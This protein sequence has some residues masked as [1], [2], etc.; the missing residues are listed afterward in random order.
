MEEGSLPPADGQDILGY[1]DDR[2]IPMVTL[3][4]TGVE[5][6]VRLDTGAAVAGILAANLEGKVRTKCEPKA[7]GKSRRMNNATILREARIDG[8]VMLG[9]NEIQEPIFSFV[10]E[11]SLIGYQVFK[12]FAITFDQKAKTVRFARSGTA[13]ITIEPRYTAGFGAKP[14][15]DGRTVW[16]ALD[17]LPAALAGLKV[18]DLI[19]AANGKPMGD[20]DVRQWRTML[21]KPGTIRLDVRRDGATQQITFDMLLAVQ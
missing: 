18:G 1:M 14:T 3:N 12:H 11:R 21:E 7:I 13:A 17:G 4:I 16:Y 5:T 8:A 19:V 9:R 6:S 10:G 20:Y 2:N 15:A